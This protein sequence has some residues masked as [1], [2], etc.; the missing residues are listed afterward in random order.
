MPRRMQENPDEQPY[1]LHTDG[2]KGAFAFFDPLA[3]AGPIPIHR[4]GQIR[5]SNESGI[6]EHRADDQF[7]TKRQHLDLERD[8]VQQEIRKFQQP[9]VFIAASGRMK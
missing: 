8:T 9:K 7:D 6:R 5:G 3:A 4:Y 2:D 1:H